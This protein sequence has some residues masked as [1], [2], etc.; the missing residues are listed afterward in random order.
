LTFYG[1]VRSLFFPIGRWYFHLRVLG[2]ENVPTEGAA[3]LAA[4]HVSWLDP[5]ALG[6]ACPRPV[7]FLIAQDVYGVP[8]SRWFYR[9]MATI[10]VQPGNP[11]PRGLRSAARALGRGELVGVFPEGVGLP[12]EAAPREAH[13]G[14]LLLG[15]LSRAP[16]VPIALSGTAA[17]WPPRCKLPRPGC[18]TVRFGEPY[19][20]WAEDRR[21]RREELERL[22][23]ELMRRIRA[24]GGG[25][26]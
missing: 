6:S 12:R 3:I 19:R 18:V 21:P 20:P 14:A 17:A 23:G 10:P 16:F 24:L 8:W 5:A 9:G 1:L 2:A 22:T 15:M 25:G 26:A 7:R 13:S 4:N 11:D